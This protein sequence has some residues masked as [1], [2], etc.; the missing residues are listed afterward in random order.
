[1]P[2]V[3]EQSSSGW[4]ARVL[5]QRSSGYG[6]ATPL[7]SFTDGSCFFNGSAG[8]FFSSA[9]QSPVAQPWNSQSSDPATWYSLLVLL[10]VYV[11]DVK[12]CTRV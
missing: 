6:E 5:E 1:V 11:V 12:Q 2:L 4:V 8:G 9:E 10:N 3:L 7:G